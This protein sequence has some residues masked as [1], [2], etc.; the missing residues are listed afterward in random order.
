MAVGDI[1][2]PKT[3]QPIYP[4]FQRGPGLHNASSYQVSAIPYVTGNLEA[5]PA[6][7][8]QVQVIHFPSVTSWVKVDNLDHL[9][10]IRV[11]FSELG[12]A[13]SS[14]YGGNFMTVQSATGSWNTTGQLPFKLRKLYIRSAGAGSA[15]INVTAGLTHILH[16]LSAS[17]GLNWSGSSGVG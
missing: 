7:S 3:G 4:G 13:A 17:E 6:A 1:T 12:T 8:G 14:S 16:D 15:D 2:D 5:P 9:H 10:E 11:G